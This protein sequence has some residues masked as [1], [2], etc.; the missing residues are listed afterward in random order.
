MPLKPLTFQLIILSVFS[1]FV[2]GNALP[3]CHP[4]NTN[5]NF[6]PNTSVTNESTAINGLAMIQ[7]NKNKISIANKYG[8]AKPKKPFTH[9]KE[10]GV[11]NKGYKMSAEIN[12]FKK[13]S[14]FFPTI[15][16]R[17]FFGI[18]F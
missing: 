5:N 12:R 14:D 3:G 18:N 15:L 1:F 6:H 8:I 4:N 16:M 11:K 10:M 13:T 7:K 2:F 9:I 17:D